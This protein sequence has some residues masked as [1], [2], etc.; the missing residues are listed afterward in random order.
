MRASLRPAIESLRRQSCCS[1]C[2]Q[3]HG[4]LALL[5]DALSALSR[6]FDDEIDKLREELREELKGC[7]MPVAKEAA[8]SAAASAAAAQ[9]LA[10]AGG[11]RHSHGEL[12]SLREAL[13]T[14]RIDHAS[15][16]ST[17]ASEHSQLQHEMRV[18]LERL[19]ADVSRLTV[20]PA[21]VPAERLEQLLQPLREAGVQAATELRALRV[22][23]LGQTIAPH[24]TPLCVKQG[25]RQ[26]GQRLSDCSGLLRGRRQRA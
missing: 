18:E 2:I 11:S 19:R 14:L 16:Q 12:Q 9:A 25:R 4:H 20:T 15:L 21:G 23:A 8:A 24:R 1:G 17:R 13:T 5:K 10:D 3:L 22:R 7:A 26:C 6:T